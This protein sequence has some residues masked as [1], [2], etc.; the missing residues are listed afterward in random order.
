M[1]FLYSD[2]ILGDLVGLSLFG[3]FLKDCNNVSY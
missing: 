2:Y 1:F 3:V